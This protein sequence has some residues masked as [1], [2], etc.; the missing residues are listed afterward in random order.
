M[1]YYYLSTAYNNAGDEGRANTFYAAALGDIFIFASLVFFAFRERFN[2]A[3]HIRLIL[4]ATIAL[5]GVAINRRPFEIIDREPFLTNIFDEAFL[6]S[7][8]A[9]DLWSMRKVHRAT[10]GGAVSDRYP[11]AR[12]ADRQKHHLAEH[13][14]LGGEPR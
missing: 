14:H 5:L 8:I 11:A 3:S 2:P 1:A 9:F 10:I 4:I 6:L 13:R 12:I 7:L